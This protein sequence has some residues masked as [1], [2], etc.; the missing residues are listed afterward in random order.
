MAYTNNILRLHSINGFKQMSTFINVLI[1]CEKLDISSHNS[2]SFCVVAIKNIKLQ[3]KYS[4]ETAADKQHRHNTSLHFSLL[5]IVGN[6][7]KTDELRENDTT[8]WMIHSLPD[9]NSH[10]N[11]IFFIDTFFLWTQKL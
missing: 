11:T 10:L 3:G 9:M 4:T 1:F 5:K 7:L 6:V 2:I 8:E